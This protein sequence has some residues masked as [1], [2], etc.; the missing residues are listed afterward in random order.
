M[1]RFEFSYSKKFKKH[2]KQLGPA[3]KEQVTTQGILL[4]V[5]SASKEPFAFSNPAQIWMCESFGIMKGIKSLP[6]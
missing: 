4:C 3:E 2:Y 6:L 1:M 5:Q